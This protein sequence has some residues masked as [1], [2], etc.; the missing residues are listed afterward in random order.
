MPPV[1]VMSLFF[2][3]TPLNRKVNAI[4]AYDCAITQALL[5]RQKDMFRI[6]ASKG[7]SQAA[8]CALTGLSASVMGQYARGETALSGPS[9]L[10]LLNVLPESI[11]SM[12]LPDGALIVRTPDEMNHDDFEDC[13]R[14]FVA[15]KGAA[16]HVDSPGGR[17][18][19]PCEDNVLRMAAARVKAA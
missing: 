12:L 9:I 5:Q 10:K 15:T 16:H 14:E 8:L 2:M 1:F 6:A 18:I 3:P 17:E 11:V 13:C 7:H 19:A 4:V